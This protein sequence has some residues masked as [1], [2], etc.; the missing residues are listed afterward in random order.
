MELPISRSEQKRRIKELEKLVEE[1]TRLPPTVMKSLPC[2]AEMLELVRE[3]TP[4]KGGARKRQV[5]YITKLLSKDQEL[6][7]TLYGFMG[8][9]QGAALQSKKEF[10]ELEYLR[11]ALLN[12]AIRY[13][14]DARENQV[15]M[16]ENWPSEVVKEIQKQSPAIDGVLL[17]RLAWL[18][19]RTRNRKQSREIFRILRAA[20]EQQRFARNRK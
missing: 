11:D 20:M 19:A 15:Q 17:K 6:S 8:E 2:S 16:E 12:E 4:L 1:I 9:R 13:L 3:T 10:H 5:K 14:E 7:E 18:F